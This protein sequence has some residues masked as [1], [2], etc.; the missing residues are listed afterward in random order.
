M[1]LMLI[2]GSAGFSVYDADKLNRLDMFPN[3]LEGRERLVDFLAKF[4]HSNRPRLK[5]KRK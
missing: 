3:T 1:K 5:K 2:P 4:V